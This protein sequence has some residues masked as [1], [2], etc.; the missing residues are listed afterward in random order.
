M[1]YISEGWNTDDQARKWTFMIM[2]IAGKIEGINILGKVVCD[3]LVS[4]TLGCLM[5]S[6]V[7]WL[8]ERKRNDLI[9]TMCTRSVTI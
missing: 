2:E 7:H 4:N 6:L 9:H 3:N 5:V 8:F 1:A